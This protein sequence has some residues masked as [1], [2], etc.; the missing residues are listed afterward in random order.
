ME[1]SSS[2][3]YKKPRD[4]NVKKIMGEFE[5][6]EYLRLALQAVSDVLDQH[7]KNKEKNAKESGTTVLYSSR[8]LP[9]GASP[10][11]FNTPS[12]N[13]CASADGG[14]TAPSSIPGTPDGYRST[15]LHHGAPLGASTPHIPPRP[16]NSIVDSPPPS[17]SAPASRGSVSTT[18]DRSAA[19]SPG[20]SYA[21]LAAAAAAKRRS[22]RP[23]ATAPVSPAPM[24]PPPPPMRHEARRFST[25]VM[26]SEEARQAYKELTGLDPVADPA[27]ERRR[28]ASVATA[29]GTIGLLKAKLEQRRRGPSVGGRGTPA[30][31]LV[32]DP[33]ADP[34]VGSAATGSEEGDEQAEA[35]QRSLSRRR[36]SDPFGKSFFSRISVGAVGAPK[37]REPD[38]VEMVFQENPLYLDRKASGD[39]EPVM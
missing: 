16:S 26:P 23:S 34:R 9:N 39:F 21:A 11:G 15:T 17:E 30:D 28:R 4:G 7:R 1:K 31:G 38:E 24:T 3:E 29:P 13:P 32:M 19:T 33:A 12:S 27:G 18:P 6:E 22:R 14:R 10:D 8:D 35:R 20:G 25:P 37:K 2:A 5:G 36:A